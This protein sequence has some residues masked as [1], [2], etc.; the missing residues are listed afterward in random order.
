[1]TEA[2]PSLEM[3]PL[4]SLIPDP[5]PAKKHTQAQIKAIA[6]VIMAVGFIDPI[7]IDH[8]NRIIRGN[9]A[10]AAAV[11]L[12]MPAVPCLRLS[13]SGDLA[14]S[15][16]IAHNQLTLSTGFDVPK[17]ADA[18]AGLNLNSQDQALIGL[19]RSEIAVIDRVAPVPASRDPIPSTQE[20]QDGQ[21]GLPATE[22]PTRIVARSYGS[23]IVFDNPEQAGAWDRFLSA[24]SLTYPDAA[25]VGER[26]TRYTQDARFHGDANT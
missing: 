26:L 16:A 19:S 1:M 13:I 12:E 18:L 17:L 21:Q 6:N 3:L 5:N 9:G 10:F 22:A 7:E 11:Y 20:G 24:L 15:Y 14:R 8:E 25:T 23:T 2:A 4:S